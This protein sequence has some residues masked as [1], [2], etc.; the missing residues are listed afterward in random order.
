MTGQP[1]GNIVNLVAHSPTATTISLTWDVTGDIF[2]E[3]FEVSHS[4]TVNTCTATAGSGM[5]TISD[6]TRRSHTLSG[7]NEDSQYTITVTAINHQGRTS[8]TARRI[9]TSTSS[10]LYTALSSGTCMCI[11]SG[12][13]IA[14]GN[15]M[16]T[17]STST[18]ITVMWDRLSCVDRNGEITGYRIQ[19][20]TTT[21]L[22]Q[23]EMITGTS[24]TDRTITASGLVPLTT[25]MFRIA[26]VNSDGVGPYSNEDN[27]DT[28]FPTGALN[29]Y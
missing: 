25:Y 18:S 20:G 23:T 10:E 3:R 15:V 9:T 13:G 11:T 24:A 17:T 21:P 28:S 29:F 27:F 22:D 12:P 8:N 5:V 1:P 26:A 19:Y 14:P 4:Y 7:L 6:G 2:I 16:F